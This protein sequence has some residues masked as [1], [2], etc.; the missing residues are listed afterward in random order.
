MINFFKFRKI[1]WEKNKRKT[2]IFVLIVMC[3]F[4]VISYLFPVFDFKYNIFL[5]ILI[6]L[7]F[8]LMQFFEKIGIFLFIFNKNC[9]FF[10]FKPQI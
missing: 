8:I 10:F 9:D 6:L 7:A 1:K 2:F 3:V 4:N 5:L